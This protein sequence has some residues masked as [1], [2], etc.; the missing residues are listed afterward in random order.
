[1][2][3]CLW[4]NLPND[5]FTYHQVGHPGHLSRM[6]RTLSSSSGVFLSFCLDCKEGN[7]GV[8]EAL[9]VCRLCSLGLQM[10]GAVVS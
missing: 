1:M 5:D 7:V 10:Q 3:V 8:N 4:A 9:N 6:S 2:T